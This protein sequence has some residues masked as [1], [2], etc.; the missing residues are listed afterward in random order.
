MF[1]ILL[2]TLDIGSDFA[3]ATDFFYNGQFYWGFAT[4]LPVFAPMTIRIIVDLFIIV[5]LYWRKDIPRFEVQM[6]ALPNIIWHIP[7]LHPIK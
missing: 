2:L 4:L 7:F 3:T 1:Y 5:M 6:Q